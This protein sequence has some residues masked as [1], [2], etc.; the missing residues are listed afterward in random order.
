MYDNLKFI[1]NIYGIAFYLNSKNV[2]ILKYF[3]FNTAMY[4]KQ[5]F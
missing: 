2:Y 4:V 1:L 5:L 3:V